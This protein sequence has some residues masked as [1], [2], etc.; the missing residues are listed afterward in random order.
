MDGMF[1]SIEEAARILGKTEQDLKDMVKQGVLREFRDGP[2]LLLKVDE[3]EEVAR[4][5]GIELTDE[6]F[7]HDVQAPPPLATI[8]TTLDTRSEETEMAEPEIPELDPLEP[9]SS[10]EMDFDASELKSLED[11]LPD[12]D[13]PELEPLESEDA[14]AALSGNKPVTA[15]KEPKAKG[16]PKRQPK[17][18]KQPKP[19][20]I[21]VQ[22]SKAPS[23]TFGE[24][25]VGGLRDDN[26]A[27]II[28]LIML[29]GLVVA[30]CVA[31]G[32]GA[33]YAMQNLL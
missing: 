24:W 5:E 23:R 18:K 30:A 10:D 8:P 12:L 6:S 22:A 20:P 9:S 16:K 3:I 27:A 29:L 13:L 19:K 15:A 1:C 31:I 7:D 11:D 25:L 14:A 2:T 26:L 33:K 32:F 28:M 17:P 21:R 4:R